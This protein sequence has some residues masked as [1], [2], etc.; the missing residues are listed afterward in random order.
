M[1]VIL[2]LVAVAA[3]GWGIMQMLDQPEMLTVPDV[4]GEAQAAAT[5]TLEGEGFEVAVV[6]E[7]AEDPNDPNIGR[8]TAQDPAQG[9]QE[10]QDTTVTITVLLKPPPVKV[11][12]VEGDTE[13]EAR[14]K[15]DEENL[16]VK[17]EYIADTAAPGTVLSQDPAAG[18]EAEVGDTVTLTVSEGGQATVPNVVGMTVE[19]AITALT[20]DGFDYEVVWGNG[21]DTENV[22]YAQD[23]GSGSTESSG[24][25]VTITAQGVVVQWDATTTPQALADALNSAGLN[26]TIDGDAAAETIESVSGPDGELTS[27]TAVAPDSAITIVPAADDGGGGGG[28]GSTTSSPDENCQNPIDPPPCEEDEN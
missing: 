9:S 3:A 28:G 2:A 14:T 4:V 27:G 13:D 26:A 17:V 1:G 16:E 21:G 6:E 11:P 10:P 5:E 23:P 8:V 20:D 24:T 7:I 15:L 22:V 19:T 18:T 25:V 12:D